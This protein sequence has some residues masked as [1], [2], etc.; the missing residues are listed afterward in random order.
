MEE[1]EGKGHG[2]FSMMEMSDGCRAKG[3]LCSQLLFFSVLADG[4]HSGSLSLDGLA[5][6]ER[7]HTHS[8]SNIT[9]PTCLTLGLERVLRTA[10][11]V[12][13][14]LST[15][16]ANHCSMPPSGSFLEP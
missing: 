15:L 1:R 16:G 9:T 10:P 7:K 3:G 14:A 8:T 12:F 11:P 2:E 4:P 13:L 6:S 5:A